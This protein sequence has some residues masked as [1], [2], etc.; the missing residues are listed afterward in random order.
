MKLAD[1]LY[2][3][4]HFYE[5]AIAYEKAIFENNDIQRINELL[6]QKS[7]CYKQNGNHRKAIQS[8][9]RV[10]TWNIGDIAYKKLKYELSLNSYLAKEYKQADAHIKQLYFHLKGKDLQTDTLSSRRNVPAGSKIS[11]ID[12]HSGGNK[13]ML[14]DGLI[15]NELRNWDIAH[16]RFKAYIEELKINEE[17]KEKYLTVLDSLYQKSN[18][19]V[20][21]S[22][23]KAFKWSTYIPGSGQIYAGYPGEGIANILFHLVSFGF[24]AEEIYFKNY[25]TGYF[26]GFA[27]LQKFYFGGR[28]RARYLAERN[29]DKTKREFNDK[30][31]RLLLQ[32]LMK[33]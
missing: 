31:K 2:H 7:Y 26:G 11:M 14:L 24:A 8:L 1:S 3:A 29:N 30:V 21:K 20:W 4:G 23:E 33:E 10:K 18:L 28:E 12:N 16:E 17:L 15:N 32:N 5:A 27:L 9:E 19:P 22:P 13:L 6:I 25:L